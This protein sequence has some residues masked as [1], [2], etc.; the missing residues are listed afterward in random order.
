M[1]RNQNETPFQGNG[2]N[3]INSRITAR[4]AER[5][6]RFH[7]ESGE[8]W[9]EPSGCHG[10]R[11]CCLRVSRAARL[12][13][14]SNLSP[15]NWSDFQALL[16]LL[17]SALTKFDIHSMS[18]SCHTSREAG[19]AAQLLHWASK[20]HKCLFSLFPPLSSSQRH[21]PLLPLARHNTGTAIT[22]HANTPNCSWAIAMMAT[23]YSQRTESRSR[24]KTFCSSR[25]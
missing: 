19:T 22:T 6:Y 1:K 18:C 3:P 10:A 12:S 4:T 15:D 14:G 7:N 24:H 21:P 23:D 13:E 8:N 16:A 11:G 5:C 9:L 25:N 17:F 2:R 20:A